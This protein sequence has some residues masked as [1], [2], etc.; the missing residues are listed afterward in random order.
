MIQILY[1]LEPEEAWRSRGYANNQILTIDYNKKTYKL[2]K[3]MLF[4]KGSDNEIVVL[5]RG[6][7]KNYMWYLKKNGFEQAKN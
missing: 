3:A 7:L 1:W 6:S 4:P 2:D 5:N